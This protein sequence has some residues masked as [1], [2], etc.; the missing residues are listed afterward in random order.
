MDI[1]IATAGL[2]DAEE[3]ALRDKHISRK[4]LENCLASGRVYLAK[5]GDKLIGWL[6]YGLFWDNTPFLNM[7]YV[8]KERWGRGCGGKLLTYW[9]E[10]MAARGYTVVMTSTQAAEQG[11]QFYDKHGYQAV[12]GFFPHA[13]P[14]E[15]ILLKRL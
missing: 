5:E 11:Q 13:E 3:L 1:H 12:G 9:E 15:L 10:Q 14:Y 6:R 8:M 2:K 7:L 4:E